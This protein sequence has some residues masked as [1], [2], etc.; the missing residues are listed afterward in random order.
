MARDLREP[1]IRA[2]RSP[3]PL[4]PC[5][6]R[7]SQAQAIV[8]ATMTRQPHTAHEGVGVAA[9][10]RDAPRGR[11]A[12]SRRRPSPSSAPWGVICSS[13]RGTGSV[14][15]LTSGQTGRLGT[16]ARPLGTDPIAIS[17]THGDVGK[18]GVAG[19]DPRCH[20]SSIAR[21]FRESVRPNR[22]THGARPLVV[23]GCLTAAVDAVR[24][25]LTELPVFVVDQVFSPATSRF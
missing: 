25:P 5:A 17:Y 11:V 4:T 16:W 9:L 7:S 8:A 24:L 10:S 23:S 22:S 2:K 12:A 18:T 21:R 15:D 20:P 3:R 6:H 1:H 13:A 19:A 14:P